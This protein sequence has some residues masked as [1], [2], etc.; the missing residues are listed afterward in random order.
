V[1]AWLLCLA[2]LL[3]PAFAEVV[4]ERGLLDPR[5]RSVEYQ[6]REVYRLHGIV[7]YQIDLEFEAGEVFE[8]L[9]GGDLE[10]VSFVA[11]GAHLFLKPK[12]TRVLTNLTLLTNRRAYQIAYSASRSPPDFPDEELVY[13]VQ[14]RYPD[15]A[16]AR[17]RATEAAALITARLRAATQERPL[18]RAYAYCG[19]GTV[20]PVEAFDDGVVTQLRFPARAEL[21]A[22]FVRE[23]DGSE[24]LVNTSIAADGAVVVERIAPMFVL[25]RGREIGCLRNLGFQGGGVRVSSGTRSGQVER[26][27]RGRSP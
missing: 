20:R 25:R 8:G 11:R 5:V 9:A 23:S 22:V 3:P 12:A 4:P 14:F 21:P 26:V 2:L 17:V 18:H 1:K 7:G 16:A 13:A 19:A 27:E 6:A 15:A 10:G 24:S